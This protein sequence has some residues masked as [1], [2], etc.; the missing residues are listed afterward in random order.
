MFFINLWNIKKLKIKIKKNL[1]FEGG[2]VKGRK[3]LNIS[4]KVV[5]YNKVVIVG[6]WF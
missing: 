2:G 1:D 3:K 6:F 4:V 5:R